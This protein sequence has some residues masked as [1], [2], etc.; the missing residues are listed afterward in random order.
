MTKRH[1]KECEKIHD[2]AL[3]KREEEKKAKQR[4]RGPYRK[5]HID[6]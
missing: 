4:K 6:W 1:N 2:E 5:A 3:K